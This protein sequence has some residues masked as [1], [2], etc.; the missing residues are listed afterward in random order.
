MVCLAVVQPLQLFSIQDFVRQAPQ[1]VLPRLAWALRHS[2]DVNR[3]ACSI[4][5]ICRYI[6]YM[7]LVLGSKARELYQSLDTVLDSKATAAAA[8]AAAAAPAR[9]TPVVTQTFTDVLSALLR[10]FAVAVE[11]DE[12][13]LTATF[14]AAGLLEV[15]V[16]VQAE[17]DTQ[18]VRMLQRF[19]EARRVVQL[20][21]EAQSRKRASSPAPGAGGVADTRAPTKQ[22]ELLIQ[23]LVLLVQ[24]SEEYTNF[25][26]GRMRDAVAAESEAVQKQSVAA[27]ASL[28]QRHRT[29][30][31]HVDVVTAS[32]EA[33]ATGIDP[34]I[35]VLQQHLGQA[36][37][38]LRAGPFAVG[39]RELLGHYMSLEELYLDNTTDMAIRIDEV[40]SGS[41]T[42]SMVDDVLFILKKCGS[43][44]LVTHSIHCVCAVL[45]QLNDLLANKFKGALAARLAGGPSKLLSAA[46]ALLGVGDA[47]GLAADGSAGAGS[48]SIE[49][50]TAI[51]NIDIAAEYIQKLRQELEG[52][53]ERLFTSVADQDRLRSVL[54][55]MTKTAADFRAMCNMALEA[56]ADGLLPK[57]RP[58]LDEVGTT[59]YQLSDTDYSGGELG[60]GWV[61][62]LAAGLQLQLNWLQPLLTAASWE[63]LTLLLLNKLIT[64][65]EVLLGRKVFSQLGGLQLDRDMRSLVAAAGELTTHPVRDKFAR[66]TQMAIVLSLESVE[67]FLD[68]W[69]DDTGHITW[70]L[71]PAEVRGILAQRADFSRDTIAALPL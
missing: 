71:T 39:V 65:L 67:E 17:C 43:R 57:L 36:E 2:S 64:R 59:S 29:S 47:A 40:V 1:A 34:S 53:S 13:L 31:G 45:G 9:K 24:R 14:G 63:T 28:Q 3:L 44:A 25:M 46:P 4:L 52:Y 21:S 11:Q 68:Y 8:A 20:V 30:S 18:G 5:L 26:A 23:E 10:E 38:K 58:I 41:L 70:R 42:S 33:A 61:S 50:A 69:G 6:D 7:R 66:L 60:T 27:A 56:V 16:G 48:S 22:L 35:A 15:V 37:A 19:V 32:K 54:V 49:H 55:D 12:Q 62:R 51:N